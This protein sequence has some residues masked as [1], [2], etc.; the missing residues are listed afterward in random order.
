MVKTVE[1]NSETS[2]PYPNLGGITIKK[3][4]IDLV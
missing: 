4:K 1:Y 3:N 2:L